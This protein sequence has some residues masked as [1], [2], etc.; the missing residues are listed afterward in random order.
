MRHPENISQIS[1]LEVNWMG[2]IFYEKSPRCVRTID[3]MAR[4]HPIN[5]AIENDSMKKVGV[6]VNATY[7]Q[8]VE[9]AAA[10][11]LNYLQLH[12]NESPELCQA[13][14]EQGFFVIKAF[15]VGAAADLQRTN[16]YEN[17][18]DFFLFDT[19]CAGY[20]GSGKQFDW[21][22]LASYQGKTPFLLSGGIH[23][24][25]IEAIKNFTHPQFAGI[26]LNSGFEI[27]PGLKDADKLEEFLD[28][29]KI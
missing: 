6:F 29:I 16:E 1:R 22:M 24:G 3:G 20:G 7:R 5:K 10:H 9:T 13:L 18:A 8:M 15:S 17:C 19:K 14:R 27:E 25:S 4:N 2:F 21:S 28:K 23:P 12:G 26:D 11:G